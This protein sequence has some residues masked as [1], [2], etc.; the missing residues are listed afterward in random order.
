MAKLKR[1]EFI[2]HTADTAIR[3]YGDTL[4]QAFESVATGMFDIITGGAAIGGT[5]EVSLTVASIDIEGLLVS[6]LSQLIV[7]HE[8]ESVVLT[9]FEVEF[10]ARNELTA[11]AQAEKFDRQKHGDGIQV[12]GVSYHMLEIHDGGTT[13]PCHVQVLFDV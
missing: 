5:E 1:Y 3:A 8:V 12:K 6:F 13:Q 10:T 4:E 7:I 11:T 9:G 2:D